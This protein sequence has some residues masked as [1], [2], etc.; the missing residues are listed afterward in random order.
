[1]ARRLVDT[2][3]DV[4]VFDRDLARVRELVD[5]GATAA[6]SPAAL[7][8]GCAE[9]HTCLPSEEAVR[10]V[11]FDTEHGVVAGA[12]PGSLIVEHSTV[13]VALSVEVAARA[14]EAGLTAIDA[15]VST[16]GGSA[17]KGELTIMVGGSPDGF[18]RALPVLRS[19]AAN[20]MHFGPAGTGTVVKLATQYMGVCNLVVAAEGFLMAKAHGADLAKLAELAPGTPAASAVLG[21]AAHWLTTHDMG[22]PGTFR[23]V[24]SIF[25]KDIRLGVDAAA[26]AGSPHR[27]GDLAV[28]L[29][30]QAMAEGLANAR[31]TSPLRA[32]EPTPTESTDLDAVVE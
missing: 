25:A 4:V 6:D 14:Q 2:G 9:V 31:F 15:P 24:V 26:D 22:E 7:S 5:H 19:L 23:G 29:W 3:H 17:E 27:V 28:S 20:V 11:L 13:A 16:G 12:R 21:H 1:M 8:A 18:E 32:L 10:D 30:E